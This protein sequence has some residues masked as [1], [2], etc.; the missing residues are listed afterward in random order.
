[1]TEEGNSH[2]KHKKTQKRGGA[3]MG[4]IYGLFC[5]FFF[6]LLP[7]CVFLCFL[8]L[9]PSSNMAIAPE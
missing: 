1:L 9:L 5:L 7:F 3:E 6:A 4:R 2:K 8:W